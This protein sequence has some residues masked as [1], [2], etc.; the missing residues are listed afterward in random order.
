MDMY[1]RGDRENLEPFC[2]AEKSKAILLK[3]L[4]LS[5]YEPGVTEEVVN[6]RFL[7]GTVIWLDI[8]Y[9]ITAG[10]AP[11]LLSHHISVLA[12]HSQTNL[13]DIMGCKNWVLFQIGRIATLHENNVQALRQ[14][15]FDCTEFAQSAGDIVREIQCGLI[16]E[17]ADPTTLVTRIFAYM[18]S[19]YL[20][21]VIHGFQKLELC[22]RDIS[23]AM[24]MLQT[25]IPTTLLPALVC[26]LYIIASIARPGDEQFF[27]DLFSSPPLLNPAL[28]H[29]ETILPVLEE[30]WSRRQTLPSFTW[31]DSLEL[32]SDILLL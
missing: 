27:R 19:L 2:L 8:T 14:G 28:K 30:I 25:Q 6:H 22:D 21:L 23:E 18:S 9:S 20:H 7:A 29:R 13:E 10:T 3:D 32:T 5:A 4:T 12:S 24:K 15:N 31:E 11:Y 17:G 26:P 16:H 1:K